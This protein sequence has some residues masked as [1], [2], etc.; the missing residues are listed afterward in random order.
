MYWK[1]ELSYGHRVFNPCVF[2]C[3]ATKQVVLF[4]EAAPIS[5]QYCLQS[6]LA[7][8]NQIS[9]TGE[10][11]LEEKV[12]YMNNIHDKTIQWET[13]KKSCNECILLALFGEE[14]QRNFSYTMLA[15]KSNLDNKSYTHIMYWHI[16]CK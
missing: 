16:H 10:C 13:R 12:V 8:A 3:F 15:N 1:L 11:I 7:T 5:M 2:V 4:I 6:L 14:F 9:W